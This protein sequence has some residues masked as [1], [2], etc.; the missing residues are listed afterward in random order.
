M[1]QSCSPWVVVSGE[2]VEALNGS[3]YFP[4]NIGIEGGQAAGDDDV[5]ALTGGTQTIIQSADA[6]SS[7][8]HIVAP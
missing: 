7:G 2:P 5:P 6:L 4:Q 8:V 1:A 3:H